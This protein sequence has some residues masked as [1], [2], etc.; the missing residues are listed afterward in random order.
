M[1]WLRG[2]LPAATSVRLLTSSLLSD[3]SPVV[4]ICSPC[5]GMRGGTPSPRV[6][7]RAD[8][9]VIRT[10]HYS[11]DVAGLWD[12]LCVPHDERPAEEVAHTSDYG[13]KRDTE[14]SDAGRELLTAHLQARRACAARVLRVCAASPCAYAPTPR[15]VST[16]THPPRPLTPLA[17]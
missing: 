1:T 7:A 10:E 13:R 6:D 14:L 8:A 3:I 4:P 9:Y 5:C 2:T 15:A 16:C 17:R 11:E 12:W